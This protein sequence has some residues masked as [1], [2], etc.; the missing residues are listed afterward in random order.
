MHH[1]CSITCTLSNQLLRTGFSL[2]FP[3]G[4]II[5]LMTPK[6]WKPELWKSPPNQSHLQWKSRRRQE[7]RPDWTVRCKNLGK[8]EGWP[9][10][11]ATVCLITWQHM[12]RDKQGCCLKNV[13]EIE[14]YRHNAF[15][16]QWQPQTSKIIITKNSCLL[17]C[18]PLILLVKNHY[19]VQFYGEKKKKIFNWNKI[20]YSFLHI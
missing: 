20:T 17:I 6:G 3:L 15:G 16:E 10:N 4:S 5:V 12:V 19:A 7:Q 2:L 11:L 1:L 9:L 18:L 13:A 14:D 8:V